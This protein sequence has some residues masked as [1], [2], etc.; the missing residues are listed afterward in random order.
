MAKKS[1]LA[2][3]IEGKDKATPSIKKTDKQLDK[4]GK[5]A[6]TTGGKLGGLGTKISGLVSK[7]GLLAGIGGIAGVT[8]AIYKLIDASSKQEVIFKKLESAI[9]ITGASYAKNKTRIDDFLSS[10][11]ATT[12]YGDTDVAPALAQMTILTGS[13]EKGFEGTTL[14]MDMASSGLFDLTTASRYVAMAMEGEVTVL[15][16]YIAGL[17]TSAGLIDMNMT[18]TEKWAVAKELLNE[19]FGGMAQRDLDTFQ[20]TMDQLR[21]YIG[22]VAERAGDVLTKELTPFFRNATKAIRDFI[23]AGGMEYIAGFASVIMTV[24]KPALFIIEKTMKSLVT[25]IEK[26]RIVGEEG[27]KW[28]ISQRNIFEETAEVQKKVKGVDLPAYFEK[29]KAEL[30]STTQAGLNFLETMIALSEREFPLIGARAPAEGV[31]AIPAPDFSEVKAVTDEYYAWLSEKQLERKMQI[32]EI[33]AFEVEQTAQTIDL[34]WALMEDWKE[35]NQEMYAIL[36]T[37]NDT[38]WQLV[39]RADMTGSQKRKA[40]W[41]STRSMIMSIIADMVKKQIVAELALEGVTLKTITT[42]LVAASAKIFKAHAGIPFAGV[43][44]AAGLIASMYGIMKGL[45]SFQ[46][47][48]SYVRETGMYMLHRGEAV[49]PR[50]E[51]YYGGTARIENVFNITVASEDVVPVM[52]VWSE[53]V[54]KEQILDLI[55]KRK[56]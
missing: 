11:Q 44:I 18:A 36:S 10:L 35:K 28:A 17:K 30:D 5:T 3:E 25:D 8:A 27:M 22:D 46:A 19:K 14:A 40:I 6:K 15:G 4:F 43:A 32:E 29:M 37:A 7:F 42:N 50:S 12:R 52:Q 47:G 34:Q 45:G 33:G 1:K 49:I 21:N 20:G 16:R 9:E 39:V 54:L 55:E 41:E 38:F 51:V 26:L 48:T 2:I 24:L 53:E 31:G 13:L 23:D 56:L